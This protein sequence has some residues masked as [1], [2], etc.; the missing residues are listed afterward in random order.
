MD[1]RPVMW[2]VDRGR[3]AWQE[4]TKWEVDSFETALKLGHDTVTYTIPWKPRNSQETIY[5]GY[6]VDVIQKTQTND[7]TGFVRKL[8]RI[9][10]S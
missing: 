10:H 9:E 2:M 7:D 4:L 3:G 6:T 5:T 1:D 8:M